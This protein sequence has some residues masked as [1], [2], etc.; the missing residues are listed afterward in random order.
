M[1]WIVIPVLVTVVGGCI[2]G[3]VGL[4]ALASASR[5]RRLVKF[6]DDVVVAASSAEEQEYWGNARAAAMRRLQARQAYPPKRYA[7]FLICFVSVLFI[8]FSTGFYFRAYVRTGLRWN[9]LFLSPEA[10][11][12]GPVTAALM[13]YLFLSFGA[14]RLSRLRSARALAAGEAPPTSVRWRTMWLVASLASITY[15]VGVMFGTS[16]SGIDPSIKPTAANVAAFSM[17]VGG[18]SLLAWLWRIPTRRLQPE[19]RSDEELLPGPSVGG[20]SL[21]D[22]MGRSV[23]GALDGSASGHSAEDAAGPRMGSDP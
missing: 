17:L 6:C 14:D 21:G 18:A 7:D 22:P 10:E 2:G 5:D 13:I 4:D 3:L 12:P 16:M 19:Q 11:T 8:A 9:D 20:V 1:T 23:R 15:S